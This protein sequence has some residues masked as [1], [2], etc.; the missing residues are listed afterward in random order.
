MTNIVATLSLVVVTNWATVS[1]TSPVVGESERYQAVV[2][3]ETLN[4]MG[5]IVTQTVATVV[6][7]GSTNA[8][9]VEECQQHG[10]RPTLT[11]HISA[12]PGYP[13]T[14]ELR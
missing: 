4:Q 1:R 14:L 3:Y 13:Y 6:W 7:K 8:V 10:P 5:T 9:V 11:R 2:R 12:P